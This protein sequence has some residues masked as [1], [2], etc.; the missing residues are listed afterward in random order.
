MLLIQTLLSFS[1][2]I[3]FHRILFSFTGM[4]SEK[5]REVAE[6]LSLFLA[7][8]GLGEG[9]QNEMRTELCAT[10]L[11]SATTT[12]LELSLSNPSLGHS[13][14]RI[15]TTTERLNLPRSNKKKINKYT[16]RSIYVNLSII[17]CK[18]TR[19][20]TFSINYDVNGGGALQSKLLQEVV[21]SERKVKMHRSRK[22]SGDS[23]ISFSSW[24]EQIRE[25]VAKDFGDDGANN[26]IGKTRSDENHHL[27]IESRPSINFEG[28]RL[29]FQRKQLCNLMKVKTHEPSSSSMGS[30]S[31]TTTVSDESTNPD[32]S[33]WDDLNDLNRLYQ[34]MPTEWI[35][36]EVQDQE[37]E[38][39]QDQTDADHCTYPRASEILHPEEIIGLII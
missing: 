32:S 5:D 33:S 10:R 19:H 2:H 11:E 36:Q 23:R 13:N 16:L 25:A 21:A 37:D 3:S 9:K 7:C 18:G 27:R 34:H 15:A 12:L 38:L 6:V 30:V 8:T 35:E 26:I 4:P 28:H 20:V 24:M 39:E 22:Q 31:T 14:F 17:M 29:E 1:S